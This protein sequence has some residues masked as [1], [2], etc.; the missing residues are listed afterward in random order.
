MGAKGVDA[1]KEILKGKK[2]QVDRACSVPFSNLPSLFLLEII[3]L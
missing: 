3:C 1:C 2:I